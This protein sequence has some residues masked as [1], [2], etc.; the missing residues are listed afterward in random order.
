M[1][2]DLFLVSP[3][4]LFTVMGFRDG[5]VR[6]L[7]GIGAIILGLFMAQGFM[8][9]LT[10]LL[11]S[12]AGSTQEGSPGLSF[13]IIFFT[14]ILASSVIYRLASDN[15]KIGG[16]ADRVLGAVFGLIQGALLASSIL[17]MMAFSGSPSRRTAEDSR[18]YKPLVNIA[19]QILDLGAEIGP[20]AVKNIEELTK[21]GGN[22]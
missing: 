17:L 11:T 18:L 8:H 1:L 3:L 6:K 21:P 4:I 7:V 16:A 14:I 10:D 20:G 2:L 13:A 15:Y 22:K 5:V 9:D 19:P 12:T